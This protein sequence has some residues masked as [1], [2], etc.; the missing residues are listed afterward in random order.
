MELS[1]GTAWQGWRVDPAVTFSNESAFCYA[2]AG[3]T[4]QL[5]KRL[6][7]RPGEVIVFEVLARRLTEVPPGT[8]SQWQGLLINFYPYEGSQAGGPAVPNLGAGRSRANEIVLRPDLQ[9][10]RL[11]LAVPVTAGPGA[12]VEICCGSFSGS[13]ASF[14]FLL[15]RLTIQHAAFGAARQVAACRLVWDAGVGVFSVDSDSPN[16]G[17]TLSGYA[18]GVLQLEA[19]ALSCTPRVA[20]HTEASASMRSVLAK[21][22]RYN[23]AAG[24]VEIELISLISG[25]LVSIESIDGAELALNLTLEV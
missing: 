16:H 14:E 20:V 1:L 12:Y 24:T 11:A 6:P 3:Q 7:V 8:A 25:E 13:D 10:Y 18:N 4:T 5:V 21:A 17:V 9:E 2:P 15:P 19:P 22:G 23:K